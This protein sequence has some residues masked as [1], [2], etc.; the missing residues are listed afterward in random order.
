MYKRQEVSPSVVNIRIKVLDRRN[1]LTDA[2]V[3]SGIIYTEDG[4]IITNEH[5]IAGADEI[6]VR[7]IDEKEYK[8]E[9]TGFNKD[10]DIAVVK[11]EASG[12]KKASFTSIENVKVGEMVIAIG[13]PFAI[14]QTVTFGVVSAKGRDL[15]LIHI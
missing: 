15:S 5:V 7:T 12:L 1:I 6:I 2:G 11:I 3:G 4:Y 8:A 13:S 10:T 9:L 14:E